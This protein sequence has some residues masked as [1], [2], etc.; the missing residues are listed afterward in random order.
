[1]DGHTGGPRARGVDRK[2]GADG[3]MHR[4]RAAGDLARSNRFRVSPLLELLTE[5]ARTRYED[6]TQ[7]GFAVHHRRKLQP[8][9]GQSPATEEAGM[10]LDENPQGRTLDRRGFLGA[11]A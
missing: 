3:R 9:N 8:A 6:W 10:S 4:L 2:D 1:G 5:P 7:R 11:S